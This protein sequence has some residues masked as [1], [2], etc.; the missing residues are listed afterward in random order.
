M[1]RASLRHSSAGKKA[2]VRTNSTRQVVKVSLA[3]LLQLFPFLLYD[4]VLSHAGLRLI[5]IHV[6]QSSTKSDSGEKGRM[7]THDS[8]LEPSM[9]G[10]PR[11]QKSKAA[12][13]SP[14]QRGP[15]SLSSQ[16]RA[17][18]TQGVSFPPLLTQLRTRT[19]GLERWLSG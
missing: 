2:P 17:T 10:K 7:P 1:A 13:H 14:E 19:P 3:W 15:I 8:H 4:T 6:M 12:G 9:A 11:W 16:P 5:S 18:H